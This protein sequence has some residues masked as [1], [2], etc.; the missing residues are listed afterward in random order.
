MPL[1]PMDTDILSLYQHGDL[2]VEGAV[3]RHAQSWYRLIR[4]AKKHEDLAAAYE[5][6]AR[7]V[8]RLAPLTALPFT[9][10]AIKRW[11]KRKELK[12][13]IPKPDLRI[14]AIVL[15]HRATLGTH[16]EKDF[17]CVP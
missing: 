3:K 12:R 13:N 4:R 8:S 17:Q 14:A 2:T 7:T 9:V 11:D 1:Y 15:D 10:A 6:P 16:N 5:R